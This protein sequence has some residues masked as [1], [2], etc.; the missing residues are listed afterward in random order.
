MPSAR[1]N[2]SALTLVMLSALLLL[3][4]RPAPAQTETVLYNFEGGLFGPDGANPE[5]S[6]TSDGKS[7]FYGTTNSGGAHENGDVFELSPN[8]SGGWNETLLYSF[9]GGT[10]G[11]FPSDTVILDSVGNL[12]GTAGGG[13]TGWGVVFELSPVEEGWTETVLYLFGSTPGD[14]LQPASGVMMDAT[15]NL[16]GATAFG[17]SVN[18]GT[19]YEMS[20]S[21]GGWT[22]QTIYN[23]DGRGP[24]DY[25][26]GFTMDAAGNIFGV[27][28]QTIT[29]LSPNGNGGWN[30]S[31]IFN[32]PNA[33]GYFPNRTIV[34]DQ[35]GNLYGTTSVGTAKGG[36]GGYGTVFRLSPRKKGGTW[37]R[38]VLYAF[39]GEGNGDGND[40][41]GEIVF[42][43][44]GNIYGTTAYG[45]EYGDG[46][47]F[48][49]VTPV[50]KSKGYTEKVLWSFNG[51]D[52]ETPVGGLILDSAGNIYGTTYSGG[53]YGWGVAFEVTP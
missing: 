3:A 22:E 32:F 11:A 15:G 8:G 45:G 46:T 48:E 2:L 47:V 53:L 31:V 7:N 17:G 12:Y 44:A 38:K 24:F 41:F 28:R 37:S 10:D 29:E 20:P 25:N 9:T 50:D 30:A 33:R 43:A 5:G 16:Y 34:T 36:L 14:G 21:G 4:A 23:F 49:L 39:E 27:S 52:G 26:T 18:Y 40:P 19:I 35:S 51:T 13:I 1:L 6:L 42:D